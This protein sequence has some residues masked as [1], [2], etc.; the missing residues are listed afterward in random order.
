LC[1]IAI[2]LGR[3]LAARIPKA[4]FIEYAGDDHLFWWG[5]T[6]SLLGDI[7]EFVTGH[8]E[9][10]SAELER[11]LATVLFTDI[12]DST[13]RAATIGDQA[14]RRLLDKHDE[15][16]KQMVKKHRG[17]WSR[18]LVTAFS[19]HSMDPVVPCDARWRSSRPPIRLEYRCE[20]VFTLG[21]L[22]LEAVTSAASQCT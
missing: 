8:R 9:G 3:D 13:R 11:I 22:K 10:T 16:A 15:L 4:K 17:A 21:R 12:I 19:Q 20:L 6:E 14:W 7:E 18:Q 5:D 2:E 1:F